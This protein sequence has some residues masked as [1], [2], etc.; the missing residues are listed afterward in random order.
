VN[1]YDKHERMGMT[2]ALKQN[3]QRIM[4]CLV[5][6]VN[7]CPLCEPEFH[8]ADLSAHTKV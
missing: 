5:C 8:G 6:H 2:D 3:R 4:R 7:L 1:K